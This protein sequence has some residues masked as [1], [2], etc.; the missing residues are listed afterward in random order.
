[1][2]F[3]FLLFVIA[4]II[5]GPL[6]TITM[7]NNLFHLHLQCDV[8]TWFAA[9]WLNWLLTSSASTKLR[10]KEMKEELKDSSNGL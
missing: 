6:F 4:I 10:P 7:L 2:P 5:I 1:M 9:L 3:L 8:S